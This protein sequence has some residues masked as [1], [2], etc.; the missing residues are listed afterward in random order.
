MPNELEI[1]SNAPSLQNRQ[2]RK[3]VNISLIR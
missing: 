1:A 2:D 3:N